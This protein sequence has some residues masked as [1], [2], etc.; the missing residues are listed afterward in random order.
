MIDPALMR[1]DLQAVEKNFAKRGKTIDLSKFTNLDQEVR[2]IKQ[3]EEDLRNKS[4]LISKEIGTLIQAG[5]KDEAEK[6]KQEASNIGDEIQALHNKLLEQQ[7]QLDDF[8]LR[9][10]N[11]LHDDVPEGLDEANNKLIKEVGEIPKFSFEPLDH[12]ALGEKHQIL[13]FDIASAMAQSRFAVLSSTGA[14]LHRA[15]AQFMLDVHTTEYGYEEHYIPYMVNSTALTNTGQLPKFG[16]DNEFFTSK[17][18]DL[19]LIPTSEVSLC[20]LAA[21]RSFTENE[22]PWKVTAHSPCFRREAGS[23]GKDTKGMLRQHQ[24]DKVELVQVTTPENSAKAQE[25]IITHAE[26]ILQR[27]KL[28]YRLVELCA[29][30]VGTAAHRTFDLEVW[31]PGQ[32]TYRE[33]S[34]IS[35]DTDF[36]ARRMKAR[37]KKS[38]KSKGNFVH[39]LNGSG[40]AVGRAWIAVIENY[41]DEAGNI[42]IPEVLQPYLNNLSQIKL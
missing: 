32:N 24:F 20:N 25:E 40:L 29:G 21:N 38:D 5:K 22:L 2:N 1:E 33:I 39:I 23:Y 10:P 27:L 17:Y 13:N 8:C 30:D 6:I 11:I 35:N 16:T 37:L 3:Q 41:Q 36:Q 19:H 26:T 12:V 28:P 7:A 4:N 34:S 31:L 9:L 42:N 14:K 15:L 18:D